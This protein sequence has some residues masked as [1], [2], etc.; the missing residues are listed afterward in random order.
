MNKNYLSKPLFVLSVLSLS[1]MQCTGPS[2][3]KEEKNLILSGD[4]ETPMRI[5]DIFNSG[6]SL[7]LRQKTRTLNKNEISG[8]TISHLTDRMLVTV[9]LPSNDG[10]GLAAPQ[11][12]IG[13]R[14]ITIQRF[15]K[16]G[17]PFEHYFNPEIISHIE[18]INAGNEGCLSIPGYKG[19]VERWQQITVSYL[20]AKGK[21][22]TEEIEGF[23]AVIFQHEIDH[24]DGV[25]YCDRITG[26]F[27]V[28]S[29]IEE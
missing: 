2:I 29:K 1:L 25:L 28:L 7:F 3:Q 4:R 12:G 11:V 6:D 20:N 13:V 5:L 19:S 24:L 22:I 15:D 16:E 8:K 14:L 23:T 9:R 17:E 27:E 10:V 18:S 21:K 26:G